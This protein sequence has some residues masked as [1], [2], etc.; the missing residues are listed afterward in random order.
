MDMSTYIKSKKNPIVLLCFL[1]GI[2]VI[3][4]YLFSRSGYA[5]GRYFVVLLLILSFVLNLE[6]AYYLLMFCFPFASILKLSESFITIS[7]L[8]FLVIIF[9]LLFL[10]KIKLK[11]SHL[12]PFLFIILAQ[13]PM[14]FLY[15]ADIKGI[16]SFSIN[17]FFVLCSAV[18][19]SKIK[20]EDNSIIKN[21]ALFFSVALC[22]NVILCDV[23]PNIMYLISMP[24]Q[25]AL[26]S[27]GR[28][29]AMFVEPNEFSQ[30]VLM[31]IGL[32]LFLIPIYKNF[33]IR[34]GLAVLI[35]FLVING[36]RSYSKAYVLVLLLVFFWL[37]IMW[38][39]SIYKKKGVGHLLLFL[40]PLAIIII[41]YSESIYQNVVLPVFEARKSSDF[42]S[43]RDNIWKNYFL[44]LKERPDVVIW[45]C[46]VGNVTCVLRIADIASGAVP[47]N[48]YL[49]FLV[50]LGVLGLVFFSC[51][52]LQ[53]VRDAKQKLS[54]FFLLSVIAFFAVAATISANSNDCLYMLMLFF[55]MPYSAAFDS[56]FAN[57]KVELDR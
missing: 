38:G 6:Q 26:E 34:I 47:H 55:A 22:V 54:S 39:Q 32:L 31:A 56:N 24:K 40:L 48:L 46:G 9:K 25:L 57:K 36:Y 14:V 30:V 49:E 19:F 1:I 20:N 12:L 2:I 4:V 8:I 29:G 52:F 13:F 50:Q 28:F 42:L 3:D 35:I 33:I 10:K 43:G 51:L 7:P 53:I 21:S 5:M 16:I 15:D 18:Y 23:F 37:F 11:Q 45:G 44:A 41:I 27:D 17:I